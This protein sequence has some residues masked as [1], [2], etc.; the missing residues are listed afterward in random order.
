MLNYE[1][2]VLTR[3]TLSRR[4]LTVKLAIETSHRALRACAHVR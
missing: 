4:F 2:P 1:R 3:V